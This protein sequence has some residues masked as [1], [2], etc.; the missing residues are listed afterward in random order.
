MVR[1]GAGVYPVQIP[2]VPV[3]F[4][5]LYF[6]PFFFRSGQMTGFSNKELAKGTSRAGTPLTVVDTLD[7]WKATII[8]GKQ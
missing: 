5:I 2:R 1:T 8:V 6:V 7:L 3:T 4:L